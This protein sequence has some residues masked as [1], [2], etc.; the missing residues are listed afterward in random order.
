[1]LES[2]CTICKG[3]GV[4]IWKSYCG[5]PILSKCIRCLGTGKVTK[6]HKKLIV[7]AMLGAIHN[8]LQ[9]ERQ[10]ESATTDES[11][12]WKVP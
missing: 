5:E 3:S 9:K 6:A 8:Q 1:M 4:E 2:D 11:N 7:Y 12:A 10:D